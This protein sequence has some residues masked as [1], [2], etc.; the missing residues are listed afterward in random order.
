[1]LPIL[2]K[3]YYYIEKSAVYTNKLIVIYTRHSNGR[4]SKFVYST[5]KWPSK[6]STEV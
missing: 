2:P 1:M 4:V 6:S 3:F 5:I